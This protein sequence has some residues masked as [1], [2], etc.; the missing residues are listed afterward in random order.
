MLFAFACLII[1]SDDGE[2]QSKKIWAPIIARVSL[3]REP[4]GNRSREVS[5]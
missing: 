3:T 5:H 1:V 2:G 4:T